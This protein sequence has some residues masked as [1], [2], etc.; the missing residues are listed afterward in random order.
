MV[1]GLF[2]QQMYQIY[3]KYLSGTCVAC[4]LMAVVAADIYRFP[5][6]L[7]V[8]YGLR[9]IFQTSLIVLWLASLL[10]VQAFMPASLVAS[11]QLTEKQ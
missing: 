3:C 2:Y 4:S 6:C 9:S 8:T 5:L 7:Y 10:Q 11:N 1:S